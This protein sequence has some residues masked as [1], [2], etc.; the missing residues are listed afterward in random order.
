MKRLMIYIF[1]IFICLYM[2]KVYTQ[3]QWNYSQ[4]EDLKVEAVNLIEN[5]QPQKGY[6]LFEEI[7]FLIRVERGLYSTDQVPYL[8][9]YM[10]WNKIVE[11]WQEVLDIGQ[12]INWVLGRNENQIENYRRLLI[13]YLYYP[14]DSECLARSATTG[15]FLKKRRGCSEFRYF[16]ADMFIGGT[17]LL[18]KIAQETQQPM[19]WESLKNLAIITSQLVY[20]VDGEAMIIETRREEISQTKNPTIRERYRPDTWIRIADEA[21]INAN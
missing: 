5:G 7:L 20:E 19:D 3:S 18:N 8:L 10:R 15:K 9:E 14:K 13:E 12:R 6:S 4:V 2:P 11:E 16:I 21:E 1:I 17:R